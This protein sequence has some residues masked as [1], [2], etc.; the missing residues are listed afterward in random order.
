MAAAAPSTNTTV[1]IAFV[2]GAVQR[3]APGVMA[4]AL[5]EANIDPGL[6]ARPD[7]RVP[8]AAFARLWMA[9]ARRI[10]DEFFGLDTRRMKVGTFAMLCH[11]LAAQATLGKPLAAQATLGKPLAGQAT[12]GKSLRMALRG[13]NLFFDDIDA[14][15]RL[16]G[17]QATVSIAN[18][19]QPPE[20]RLFA[21]ETL[22]VML[23][24]LVCWLAGRRVPLSRLEWAHP[25]PA[26][27]DEYRRM[28]SPLLH[29]DAPATAMSFDARLLQAAV[30]VDAAALKAFLRDAP[31]SVFLKQVAASG[32]SDRVRRHCR[33][34]LARAQPAPTLDGL[35]AAL[36]LSPATLRR[37]LADEGATWQQLKDAVRRELALQHLAEGR[38]TVDEI[39][40]RLGFEDASTFYRAFRKW[41]G[42]APGVWRAGA[43]EHRPAGDA[44]LGSM[45][46]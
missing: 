27:A 15:L 35:A 40:S 24:G 12:L 19:I 44:A 10:D 16:A 11:A 29:F 21:E 46:P 2:R 32:W 26:H 20:A 17:G 28:F 45:A 36:G 1:S 3:L 13:F 5:H 22:L 6:L 25:R 41:T 42:V 18:R 14:T 23:H 39:A 9:I 34:A 30:Q 38:L 8:A 33:E 4:A 37:R 31:Q 7:A 43:G